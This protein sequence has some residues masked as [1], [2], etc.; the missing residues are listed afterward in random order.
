MRT[1]ILL[2][3]AGWVVAL[4]LLIVLIALLATSALSPGLPKPGD[5]VRLWQGL[6]AMRVL[7]VEPVDFLFNRPD[8]LRMLAQEGEQGHIWV[9]TQYQRDFRL[10]RHPLSGSQEFVIIVERQPPPEWAPPFDP[11]DTIYSVFPKQEK[12]GTDR[13]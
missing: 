6:P 3:V 7:A 12:Q 2:A 1:R 11:D 4:V 9:Y 5:R 8:Q 13:R 10:N